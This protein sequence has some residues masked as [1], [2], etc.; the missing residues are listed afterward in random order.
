M[1][2]PD[3]GDRLRFDA[4]GGLICRA[5]ASLTAPLMVAGSWIMRAVAGSPRVVRWLERGLGRVAERLAAVRIEIEG[6]DRIDLGEQYVVVPLH[7][8]F[9]D[10]LA[11]LRLPLGLRF[12]ARDELFDWP[13]LGGYLSAGRHPRVDTIPSASS[14]R[15]FLRQ[16]EE[17]FD[18]GDS[19]VVFAQGSILGLEVAFQPGAWRL[20]RRLGRPL[21]PVILT[22]A[23]RVWEHPYSST[24]RFGR[25]V[26]MRI[27]DPVPAGD[28]D[29]DTFRDV[30]REMKRMA[31]DG[32]GA[33]PRRFEP[34]RDGWWDGYPFEIDAD[35][36][37][38]R[39]RV[40]RHRED[41]G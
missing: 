6:T 27:L 3:T 4:E 17:V 36:P 34:E 37:E 7:E 40:E 8:G 21:L 13:A 18:G 31:L 9:A 22:G 28:L 20:A 10:A 2:T 41:A 15:R 12:A 14:A 23:H 33:A 16:V 32:T 1:S 38:L 35:F 39:E 11:L 24:V 19:L 26:S 29:A 5:R 25:R 30:E